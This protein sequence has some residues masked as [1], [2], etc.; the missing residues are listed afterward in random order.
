M[1]DPMKPKVSLVRDPGGRNI[2]F[3]DE[4]LSHDSIV[5]RFAPRYQQ[6][7]VNGGGVT[8]F[9]DANVRSYAIA[10]IIL[11]PSFSADP[12]RFQHVTD[13]ERLPS[14]IGSIG[15][16]VQGGNDRREDEIEDENDDV[17]DGNDA[18]STEEMDLDEA[19]PDQAGSSQTTEKIPRPS[20]S[21]IIFRKEKSKELRES[22]PNMSAG[23][24]STEASRQW[25]AMS[26]ETKGFYQA[27]AKE[28]ALQHKIKY[29]DYHYRPGRK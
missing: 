9:F 28:E 8:I 2:L 16:L 20:N 11:K 24:I 29:P 1:A 6:I 5:T 4:C 13:L 23:E 17:D 3:L 22:K 27:M 26:D 19:A 21:W 18:L 7:V 15:P 25:K 10:P 14:F 12:D